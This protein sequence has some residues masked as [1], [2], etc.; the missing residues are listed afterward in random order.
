MS[1]VSGGGGASLELIKRI[2][3]LEQKSGAVTIPIARIVNTS[4]KEYLKANLK[5]GSCIPFMFYGLTDN[6]FTQLIYGYGIAFY[7]QELSTSAWII[8]HNG[9][10]VIET[11]QISLN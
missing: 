4:I 6:P 3:A 9:A 2:E 8:A 7:Y 5:N 11:K 1:L 10:G